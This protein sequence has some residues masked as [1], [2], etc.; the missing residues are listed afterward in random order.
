[1][2]PYLSDEWFA[3]WKTALDEAE[4]IDMNVWIYDENSYPS[5]FAGGFVPEALPDSRGM[6]LKFEE[7]ETLDQLDK[8]I[9]YVFCP[10]ENR[11]NDNIAYKN[12][13]AESKTAGKLEPLPNGQ[14]YLLG[15]IHYAPQNGWFGGKWY[16][17][18]LK[19]GVTEKFFEITLDAYKN[20]PEIQKEFGKRVPGIFTDEPYPAGATVGTYVTWNDEIP[21]LFE[22]RFGYSLIDHLPSLSKNISDWKKIRHN[23]HQLILDLFIERWAKPYFERC[24]KYGLEFTGHYC[25]NR[26]SKTAN[27]PVYMAMH[28]W[29]QRPAI[30]LL[31]NNYNDQSPVSVHGVYVAKFEN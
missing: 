16:I 15:K 9:W 1:M 28:V 29:R 13:T 10:Q 14:K 6:G 22:K 25:E 7:V 31:T 23:Y 21:E 4:K 3:R 20:V 26:W 5:G 19:K 2:T 11:Q 27:C 18:L 12:I 17:D 24:E 8:N 30:D